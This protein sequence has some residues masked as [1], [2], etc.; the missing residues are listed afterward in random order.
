MNRKLTDAKGNFRLHAA[1]L[2]AFLA[3]GLPAAAAAADENELERVVDLVS[4]GQFRAAE[5]RIDAELKQSDLSA[6]TRRAFEFQRERMAR[7]RYDFSLTAEQVKSKLREQIPDLAD[8]DVAR[9]DAQGLLEH[10][11]ID[12]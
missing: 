2:A 7:M 6:D 5:I 10:M 3:I 9:W 12:G 11:A 4:A 1:M 8:S